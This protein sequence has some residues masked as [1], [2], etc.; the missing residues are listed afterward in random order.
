MTENERKIWLTSLEVLDSAARVLLDFNDEIEKK[1]KASSNTQE[2]EGL[3]KRSAQIK[4]SVYYLQEKRADIRGEK[5]FR[6]VKDT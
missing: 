4:E 5:P 3:R 2:I 6:V 1:I